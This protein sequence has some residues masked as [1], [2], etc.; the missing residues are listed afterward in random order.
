MLED[1]RDNE[2]R[3]GEDNKYQEEAPGR[4]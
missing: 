3:L 4:W 2:K 1:N